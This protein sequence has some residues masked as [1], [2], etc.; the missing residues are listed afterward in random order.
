[1]APIAAP[2]APPK[3]GAFGSFS[4]AFEFYG[5]IFSL[6]F[7]HKS[8]LAPLA[9]DLLITTLLSIALCA[10]DFFV[11]SSAVYW[12]TLAVGTGLLYF[13]DYFCNSLTA[14]LIYDQ[15]TT[16]SSSTK[17]AW[18]RVT[19]AFGG[20]AT[21]A[22][23][24]AVLDV[25]TTYARERS[26]VLSRILL[27]ILRRIWTTA[28]Y[29]IMPALVLEGASFGQAFKRSKELMAEDPTGVGAGVVA[30]SL[31]SYVVGIV[32][33]GL[34]GAS[35]RLLGAHVHPVVGL[36][37]FFFFCNAYWAVSG[38]MKIAYST[39]FYMWAKECEANRSHD[40]ALAPLPLRAALD[41][42]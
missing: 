2:Y 17:E 11:R 21:F 1:V 29:C 32:M 36:F 26:D 42:A 20:I 10:A 40:H 3:K 16:G 33:F 8:L 30:L 31:T 13:I 24:S 22:A 27:D 9:Y 23:V 19:R 15:V 7:K 5:Q 37:F 38:W 4:R 35:L 34:A 39:C 18:P 6:A 28:T 12:A 41:A 14:S 25:A